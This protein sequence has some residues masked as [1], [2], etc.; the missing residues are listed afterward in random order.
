M[1][2]RSDRDELLCMFEETVDEPLWT[3]EETVDEPLW[4]WEEAVVMSRKGAKKR[5]WSI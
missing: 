3:C 2:V 4:T 1:Y 5:S